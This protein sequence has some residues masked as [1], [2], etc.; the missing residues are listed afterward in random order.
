MFYNFLVNNTNKFDKD[1]MFDCQRQK[2]NFKIK[3]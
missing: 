2:N 1:Y 3:K